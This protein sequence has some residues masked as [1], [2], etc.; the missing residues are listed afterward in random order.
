MKRLIAIITC[1]AERF[2]ALAN[3]QRRTWVPKVDFADVKFFL[4]SSMNGHVVGGYPTSSDE[5]WLDVDDGYMGL[6]SKIK[7]MFGWAAERGYESTFKTDDDVWLNPVH[8]R[9][10]AIAAD[11]TGRFRDPS[12][13]FPAFYASGF[14]YHLSLRAAERVASTVLNKDWAEDRFIG[15]CLAMY[16]EI[17]CLSDQ[18]QYMPMTPPL[19]PDVIFRSNVRNR[20]VYCEYSTEKMLLDMEKYSN[21][22]HHTFE[23]QPTQHFKNNSVSMEQYM[24]EPN[25]MPEAWKMRQSTL[26]SRRICERCQGRGNC[27]YCHSRG[28][29]EG[30]NPIIVSQ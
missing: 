26:P 2:R 24:A 15:N 18:Y 22:T 21:A 25:D 29:V 16:P 11:Y 8:L 17:T 27:I 3:V 9:Q 13:A 28:W 20:S 4:G 6:P 10:C 12:G 14:A 19:Q 23:V 1:H 30:K 5:V 7:A